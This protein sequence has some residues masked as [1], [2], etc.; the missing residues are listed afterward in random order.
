MEETVEEIMEEI[1][2]FKMVQ[3]EQKINVTEG[4]EREEL[5]LAYGRAVEELSEIQLRESK[6]Y[7]EEAKYL[8]FIEELTERVEELEEEL[9]SRGQ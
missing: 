9:A 5:R 7:K 1:L 8:K 6:K 2:E 3:I 4:M